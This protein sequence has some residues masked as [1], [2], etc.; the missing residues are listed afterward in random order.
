MSNMS[1]ASVSVPQACRAASHACRAS[2][3]GVPSDSVVHSN[4]AH[5]GFNQQ[6]ITLGTSASNAPRQVRV[7]AKHTPRFSFGQTAPA[8]CGKVQWHIWAEA[9]APRR[10]PEGAGQQAYS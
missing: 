4:V 10:S 5:N 8:L 3:V 2:C 1:W 9:R 7:R 6:D